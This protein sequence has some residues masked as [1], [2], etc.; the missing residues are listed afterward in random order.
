M[1]PVI[2][3]IKHG[4]LSTCYLGRAPKYHSPSVVHY[5]NIGVL[6]IALGNEIDTHFR[7]YFSGDLDVHWGYD[8]DFDPWP[9][10]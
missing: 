10:H 5:L 6:L 9:C 8:L 1:N 4:W 2:R 3:G 7:T